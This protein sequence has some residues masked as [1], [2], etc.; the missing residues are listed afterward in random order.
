MADVSR[1]HT[2]AVPPPFRRGL[3]RVEAAGYIG[4]SPTSF[5]KLVNSGAMPRPKRVGTRNIWDRHGLDVAFEALPGDDEATG[6]NEWD[7]VLS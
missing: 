4:I 2:Q 1:P 5:D 7:S 6:K 3:N